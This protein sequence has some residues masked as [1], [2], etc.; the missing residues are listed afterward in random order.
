MAI[1]LTSLTDYVAQERVPLI[2]KTVLGAKTASIITTQLGAKGPT[3]LNLLNST[4]YFGDGSACGFTDSGS[5]NFTVRQITPASIKVNLSFCE[6]EMVDKWMQSQIKIAAGTQ[7][8]PFEAEILDNVIANVNAN[9]ET[10]IWQGNTGSTNA[11]LNKFQGF[12]ELLTSGA[13][14]TFVSGLTSITKT[15]VMSIVDSMF[16]GLPTAILDKS[17]VV[18]FCG[19]DTFRFYVSAL[20]DANLFNYNYDMNNV[21]ELV[22]PGTSI[23]LISVNGLAGTS[24]LYGGQLSNF[25]Y[26]TDLSGDQEKIKFRYSDDDENFKL[27]IYF[28]AG[29]QVAYPDQIVAYKNA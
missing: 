16:L 11:N 7:V 6:K 26:G 24:K 21:M 15:N 4:V 23:R 20:R 17:D 28:T 10:A 3:N 1:N 2:A 18:I 14:V 29:V 27:S 5:T 22:I 25:F 9:L 12:I 19:P 8:L 13:G